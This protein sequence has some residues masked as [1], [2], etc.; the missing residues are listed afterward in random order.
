MTVR[1]GIVGTSWWADAMYM[2][3]LAAHPDA[4]V[5]AVCGRQSASTEKF[6]AQWGIMHAFTDATLMMASV[7]MDAI[8]V[9]TSNDSH[10]A[11]TVE[12]LSRGIHV[13]CEK[14]LALD[15][16][17][18]AEMALL[19]N[20]TQRITMVP[21]T[22]R[23]MPMMQ[24]V[25]RLVSD[26]YVG[27]V[28]HIN[29]RYYANFGFD[30]SYSWRFDRA[31]AGAGIIGDL[32]PHWIHVSRWL[33]DDDEVSVSAVASTF[34]DRAPR[35]DGSEYERLEDSAVMTVRY[36]SGAYG[37]LQTSAVCWE[38]TPF[39][40]THHLE[41]HGDAG[42]LYAMCDWDMVQEVRGLR[43]GE[44]GG[45]QN[46]PIPDDLLKGLRTD[47]VH[48]TYRDVFRNTDSM[49]RAW[50]SAIGDGRRIEPS[51]AE[52]LAVQR[53]VDAAVRSAELGGSPEIV[54]ASRPLPA[55]PVASF[56]M[57]ASPWP[58][59]AN[60]GCDV[61]VLA[62]DHRWQME[63]MADAAGADRGSIPA[64]KSLLFEAFEYVA[65][66]RNDVGIL[67]DDLYGIEILERATGSG[68]WLAHA[69]D[70]PRSRP[71]EFGG[72]YEVTK[73]LAS[74]PADHIAKLMV[75][76]HPDDPA[77]IAEAQWARMVQFTN[78]SAA[79]RR[80]ILIEF[81]APAGV[82]PGPDYLPRM[83][84]EAYRRGIAPTWWKL[85]PLPDVQQWHAAASIIRA[86]DPVCL[87]MLVLGQTADPET[88][89]GALGAAA[90][91]PMVRGFAIGRAIFGPAARAWFAGT[92]SDADVVASVI[93][94]YESTIA[95]WQGC[96]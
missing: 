12:A 49:T 17:Q 26:G 64:L 67:V 93:K 89:A 31:T 39:G 43:R 11:L 66:G 85:P 16:D 2:P 18:A 79:S 72:G 27:R 77:E 30:D 24:W 21:F 53:V 15:A 34:T 62:I 42:T 91:E 29:M 70:I 56:A 19:A 6:A 96:R 50:I 7:P 60:D 87:G 88:L 5:V 94:Q 44:S 65:T 10:Y 35:P 83:L 61:H 28:L 33:L 86:C 8:I 36:R 82:E 95:T 90:S 14:P 84:T 3:A 1:V 58:Q 63:E 57:P 76:A 74:W 41:I 51:F 52:G 13:L 22:Y 20:A 73:T 23:Y 75:Y 69:L 38:G 9:A 68:V 32:G 45:A 80:K 54:P 40:Q 78:A 59:G 25:K 48:N 37:V 4:E 55:T 71:V 81:Q 46:L 47:T 92:M